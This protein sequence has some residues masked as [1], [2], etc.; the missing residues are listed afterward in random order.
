M[1]GPSPLV[2]NLTGSPWSSS[3]FS[4]SSSAHQNAWLITFP[5]SGS[6]FSVSL[7]NSD[8]VIILFASAA[9]ILSE[10]VEADVSGKKISQI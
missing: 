9:S 5:V 8:T 2:F 10:S 6:L 7:V 4:M 1:N 3:I